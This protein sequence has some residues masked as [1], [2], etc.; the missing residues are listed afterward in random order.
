MS[1]PA[2]HPPGDPGV[3]TD[4]E[5]MIA[6]VGRD[7]RA[8]AALYDRHVGVVHGSVARFLGDPSLAEELVQETFL[9]LWERAPQYEMTA[10][11]VLG[12][13]LGI[14]RNKSIDR[15]RAMGRRPRVVSSWMPDT[16]DRGDD[17][18]RYLVAGT[19]VGLSPEADPEQTAAE[20]WVGSIVRATLAA[21]PSTDRRVLELAYDE[22]LSQR[23]IADRLGWPLGTV[24][25]RTRRAL[26]ALRSTLDAV[27][28]LAPAPRQGAVADGRSIAQGD[29]G[30]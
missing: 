13:M 1:V 15:L 7:E 14:A 11:T 2:S 29:E 8:F 5:L 23:E 17:P 4:A 26:A 9:A 6:V 16:D 21:M 27:P 12:W 3:P 18:E 30:R 25:S 10:G 19:V 20:R 28:D 22:G 24:K